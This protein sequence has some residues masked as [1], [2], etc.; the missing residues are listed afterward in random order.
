MTTLAPHPIPGFSDPVSSLTH[1]AGAAVF[2][3]LSPALLLRGRG[4]PWG[5]A[6]LAAFAFAAVLLLCTSGVYH[7]LPPGT[8]GRAVLRRLD[9]AAIYL[10][11]AGTFTPVHGLLFRGVGRWGPLVLLWAL[12]AAGVALKAAFIDD[13][14][15]W[16]GLGTYLGMGWLGAVSGVRLW[17]RYGEPFVRPLLG[18]GL[19]Y[20]AGAVLDFL[21]WP[22]PVAGVLGPHELFHL[23]VLAGVALHWKFVGS[24]AGRTVPPRRDLA[25]GPRP[26]GGAGRSAAKGP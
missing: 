5:T 8:G 23:G 10:L 15:D 7:L 1:L 6:C 11:I 4:S 20:S 24:F 22:V 18:G 2:L 19:A 12:A 26:T 13:V 3:G 17:R 14:P 9:H 25:A 21:D 16:V